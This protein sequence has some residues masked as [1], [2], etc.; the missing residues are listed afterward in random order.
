[1]WCV[2]CGYVLK[3]LKDYEN[4]EIGYHSLHTLENEENYWRDIMKDRQ[5]HKGT[6]KAPSEKQL[7]EGSRKRCCTP[8]WKRRLH[9]DQ[10]LVNIPTTEELLGTRVPNTNIQQ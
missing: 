8:S 9:H 4:K 10:S 1:M 5:Y 3:A 6:E 2:C 7:Q